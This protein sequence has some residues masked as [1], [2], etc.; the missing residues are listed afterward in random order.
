MSGELLACGR[1]FGQAWSDVPTEAQA[2]NRVQLMAGPFAPHEAGLLRKM[3][4]DHAE[5]FLVS[6]FHDKYRVLYLAKE[7]RKGGEG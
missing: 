1:S 4:G 7:K 6:G 5:W 3:Q 2:K